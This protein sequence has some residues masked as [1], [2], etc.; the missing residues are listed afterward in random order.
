MDSQPENADQNQ[1]DVE[2]HVRLG[3]AGEESDIPMA[4]DVEGHRLRSGLPDEA[5]QQTEEPPTEDVE[6]HGKYRV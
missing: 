5:V 4:E 6:G 1:D 3:H 2:G